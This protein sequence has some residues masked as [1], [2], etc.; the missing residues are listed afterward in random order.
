M[1]RKFCKLC[2]QPLRHERVGVF[3]PPIKAALFDAIVAG[4]DIG[5]S[6][7]EL[8]QLDVFRDRRGGDRGGGMRN[9]RGHVWQINDL[10]QETRLR[11]VQLD[12][13]YV[14]VRTAAEE[15]TRNAA[16]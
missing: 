5:A 1:R 3:L 14:L 12:R 6:S 15:L 9:V 8:A 13:R 16:E 10:L 2:G 11:I 4:G 7:E